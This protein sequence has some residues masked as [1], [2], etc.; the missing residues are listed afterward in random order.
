MYF[1]PSGFKVDAIILRLWYKRWCISFIQYTKT[2]V[3]NYN[4]GNDTPFSMT[5]QTKLPRLFY[6][7]FTVCLLILVPRD[8]VHYIKRDHG[9]PSCRA[10]G[11]WLMSS[12]WRAAKAKPL[13]RGAK[14]RDVFLFDIQ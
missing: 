2:A 7:Q 1:R 4:L 5:T 9:G 12:S 13:P 3:S 11:G 14:E 10:P 6:S 8:I